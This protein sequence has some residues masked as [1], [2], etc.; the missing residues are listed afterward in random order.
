MFPQLIGGNSCAEYGPK[1]GV[2]VY[3]LHALCFFFFFFFFFFCFFVENLVILVDIPED[4]LHYQ[5]L[6]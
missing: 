3:T 6:S 4:A 2:C 1:V 5:G